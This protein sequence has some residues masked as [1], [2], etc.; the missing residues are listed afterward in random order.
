MF[1][2]F[3]IIGLTMLILRKIDLF[4]LNYPIDNREV[5]F[6][7]VSFQFRSKFQCLN[8]ALVHGF[9]HLPMISITNVVYKIELPIKSQID[10]NKKTKLLTLNQNV[11]TNPII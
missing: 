7:F 5:V 1:L 8:R 10:L 11:S 9:Y 6:S 2:F 4:T 3:L